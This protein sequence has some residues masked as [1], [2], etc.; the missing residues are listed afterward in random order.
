MTTETIALLTIL[1]N[2]TQSRDVR[3]R[4]DAEI[5]RLSQPPR[6][7]YVVT[8]EMR[9]MVAHAA[10]AVRGMEVAPV[11][12]GTSIKKGCAVPIDH[13]VVVYPY[14]PSDVLTVRIK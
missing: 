3:K 13:H 8:D 12:T 6:P 9:R 5:E 2:E 10:D 14:K 4:C 11:M 1:R 7:P